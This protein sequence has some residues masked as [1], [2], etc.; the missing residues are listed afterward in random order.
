[1]TLDNMSGILL[2][3][4]G[5]TLSFYRFFAFLSILTQAAYSAEREGWLGG[6]RREREKAEHHRQTE[7]E[8]KGKQECQAFLLSSTV[9]VRSCHKLFGDVYFS[10]AFE[11]AGKQMN[12]PHVEGRFR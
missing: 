4:I 12:S 2:L 9:T 11:D 6:G 1:M 5:L 7:E 10:A 3:L 8:N